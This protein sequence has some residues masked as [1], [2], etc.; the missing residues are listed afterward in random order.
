MKKLNKIIKKIKIYIKNKEKM[1]KEIEDLK[2]QIADDE[3]IIDFII[4]E[5]NN[6]KNRYIQEHKKYLELYKKVHEKEKSKT[7]CKK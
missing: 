7:K 5:N 3:E 6:H 2:K 4:F 1:E